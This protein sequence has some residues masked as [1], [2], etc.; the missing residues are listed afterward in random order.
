M[1]DITVNVWPRVVTVYSGNGGWWARIEANKIPFGNCM[2][3]RG[4]YSFR[5]MAQCAFPIQRWTW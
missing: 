4:P 5:W 1:P 3:N 2:M